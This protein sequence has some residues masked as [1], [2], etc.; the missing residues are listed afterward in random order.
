MPVLPAFYRIRVDGAPLPLKYLNGLTS[1]EVETSVHEASTFRLSFEMAKTPFGDWDLLQAD[2]FRPMVRVGISV[3]L[4]R[5]IPETLLNGFVR[6]TRVGTRST[7]GTSALE[8]VGFDATAALM[9]NQEQPKSHD[10]QSV[11][12]VARQLFDRY[13]MTSSVSDTPQTRSEPKQST[14]QRTSDIRFLRERAACCGYE[15]YVQ[16]DPVTGQDVGHFHL[17]L[18]WMPSQGE[19]LTNFGLATN[20]EDFDVAYD[21]LQPTTV[22]AAGLDLDTRQL[23]PAPALASQEQAMG[24]EAT[25]SRIPQPPL[26]RPARTCA[27]NDAERLMHSQAIADRSSRSLMGSGEV[28]GLKY[29]KVLRVGLP[30]LIR[31]AGRDYSGSYYVTQVTHSISTDH[32]TQRFQAERNA[33]GLSGTESFGDPKAQ[34]G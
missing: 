32:Y 11:S 4:G 6:E 14:R 18:K 21:A 33:V 23:I 30:V 10:N 22:L 24:R 12:T 17:P 16:P 27:A 26:I 19:I 29:G 2:L 9:N 15:C 31:G 3:G 13:N 20:L 34:F 28:D 25:L 7:P 1:I 5:L 8:V